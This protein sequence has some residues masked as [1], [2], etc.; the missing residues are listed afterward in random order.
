MTHKAKTIP[1]ASIV[2]ELMIRSS[3]TVLDSFSLS[4]LTFAQARIPYVGIPREANIV[5]YV[6]TELANATFPFPTDKSTREM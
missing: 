4:S 6:M 2:T 3:C 1:V 5:K